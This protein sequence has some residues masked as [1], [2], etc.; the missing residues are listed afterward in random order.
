MGKWSDWLPIQLEP[1]IANILAFGAI[2]YGKPPRS[3][4]Q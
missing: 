3:V 2:N 1:Q 4:A